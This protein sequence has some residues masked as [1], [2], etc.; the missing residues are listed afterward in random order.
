MTSPFV[1]LLL[2]FNRLYDMVTLQGAKM[3]Y[4]DQTLSDAFTKKILD[5]YHDSS[6]RDIYKPFFSTFDQ[7]SEFGFSCIKCRHC[8]TRKRRKKRSPFCNRNKMFVDP[9]KFHGG[10]CPVIRIRR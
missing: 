1:G 3:A 8:G 4:L 5:E 2:Y 9:Y 7:K 6:M 10:M